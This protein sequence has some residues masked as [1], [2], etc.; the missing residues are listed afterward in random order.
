MRLNRQ[1]S[2]AQT[3]VE[4]LA[5]PAATCKM[6]SLRDA[7]HPSEPFHPLGRV[8]PFI[9]TQGGAALSTPVASRP[10]SLSARG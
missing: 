7:Q 1:D 2:V 9:P 10:L 8:L 4:P 6:C 5:V 3:C